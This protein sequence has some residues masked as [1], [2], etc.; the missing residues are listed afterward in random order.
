MAEP[1][2][3][4]PHRAAPM[5]RSRL[6][7]LHLGLEKTKSP[8]GTL[9][10]HSKNLQ[11]PLPERGQDPPWAFRAAKC[12]AS[13]PM[14]EPPCHAAGHR[15]KGTRPPRPATQGWEGLGAGVPLFSCI[16]GSLVRP[17]A[18]PWGSC[19]SGW[20]QAWLSRSQIWE[21]LGF[22]EVW[23]GL[24]PRDVTCPQL[25]DSHLPA[26]TQ[27]QPHPGLHC[28]PHAVISRPLPMT[29]THHLNWVT[30]I[31]TNPVPKLT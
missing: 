2:G 19:W 8:L 15:M 18:E 9:T 3:R 1:R 27:P 13:L 11:K 16:I 22:P 26:S 21:R 4:A 10:G 20:H 23:L 29:W 12:S 28:D 5:G 17:R 31:N 24:G 25:P 14:R 7:A 30:I 6:Q